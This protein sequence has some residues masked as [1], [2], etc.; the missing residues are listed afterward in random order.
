MIGHDPNRTYKAAIIGAGSGG[1]TMAIGLAG[2][3]HDVVLIEGDRIGGDCTNVG[4]IPSK[5]LL[6]AADAGQDD[7]LAW[8]RSKRDELAARE[9]VEMEE[10]EQIHLVRGWARLT[11]RRG[12]HVVAVNGPDGEFE[13]HADNVIVCG[14]S[15]P[16]MIPIDGLGDHRRLTNENIFDLD[17]V[18]SSI[19]LVGGGVIALELATAFADLGT[20][21]D[22]VELADRLIGTEDPL[23]S[24]T[25]QAALEERGVNVH[26][27]TSITSFDESSATAHLANSDTITDVDK[28]FIGVGR[29]PRLDG[30]GLDAA[31][32]ESTKRGIVADDWGRTSV[33]GIFAVGDVT[34]NTL[35]THGANAIG[36]RTVRAIALSK[37]PKTG[38]PRAMANAV[39]SRPQIA[40]VGMS[41][42]DLDALT[43]TGRARYEVQLSDIDRGFTDDVRHGFVAVDVERFS[44]KVLRAVIVGPS[45]GELI[46][47]FTMMIDHGIG[48]RKVFG[49]VHP[50]PTY[51]LAIG[52]IADDFARAT[53]PSLPKEWWAMIRGRLSARIKR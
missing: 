44:G 13:V 14:G 18:P 32:L 40:S 10:H 3:G 19:V 20:R 50:Y 16:I 41:I 42:A 12:P 25:M 47:M 21:V 17:A 4:C 48:L 45:A 5:A 28:V 29:R 39:Y 11:G 36:R 38:K 37:L 51:A 49:M 30:L 22:I 27:A 24:Q 33:D 6:H 15:Q 8:V 52:Q 7:P 34:G 9:D 35:T 1:L 26:T 43:T 2:F 53:Y 23:V 31:G 46:G